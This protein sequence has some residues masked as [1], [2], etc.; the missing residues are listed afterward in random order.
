MVDHAVHYKIKIAI[1]GD[2]GVGKSSICEN[3][4]NKRFIHTDSTISKQL[5]YIEFNFFFP[6]A[7]LIVVKKMKIGDKDVKLELTDTAGQEVFN[8][9]LPRQFFQG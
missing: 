7:N 1:V 3:F 2:P 6:I 9:A 5:A 8:N 4:N